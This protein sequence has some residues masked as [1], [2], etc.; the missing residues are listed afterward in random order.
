M[1]PL[2]FD[3]ATGEVRQLSNGEKLALSSISYVII[4]PDPSI[5]WFI[6]HNLGTYLPILS[7]SIHTRTGI[8]LAGVDEIRSDS[9]NTYLHLTEPTSGV[10]HYSLPENSWNIL[11]PPHAP[12]HGAADGVRLKNDR[13]FK[14]ILIEASGWSVT[15][16]TLDNEVGVGWMW[17]TPQF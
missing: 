1:R 8:H 9:N 14:E 4:Y 7:Y 11:R 3:F 15:L 10:L 17:C 13:L 5:D 12:R 6:P 16:T 2:V